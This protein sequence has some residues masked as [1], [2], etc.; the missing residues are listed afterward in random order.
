MLPASLVPAL[1]E[2]MAR[3]RILWGADHAAGRGGVHMPDAL[4]RKYPRAGASWSW[5][6]VFPQ[7][8]L[9]VDPRSGVARRHHAYARCRSC[10]A[11]PT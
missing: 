2:Q 4:D 1:R 8:G 11:T 9:S 7:A 3:A 6:F 10:S 5:F